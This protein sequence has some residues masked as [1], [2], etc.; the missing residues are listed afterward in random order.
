MKNSGGQFL[1]AERKEYDI[2]SFSIYVFM[3][4]ASVRIGIMAGW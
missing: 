3:Y 2:F 1:T 4:H